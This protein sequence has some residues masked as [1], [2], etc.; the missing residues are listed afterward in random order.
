M[1][2][3]RVLLDTCV[4]IEAF[5][6]K[7]WKALCAHFDVETVDCCVTECASGSAYGAGRVSVPR[8]DLHAGLAKVHNVDA[9][10]L[11]ALALECP[12]LPALDDGELHIMA[13]LHA[14]PHAAV[15]TAISTAD[16]AAIRATHVMDLLERVRSLQDLARQAGVDKKQLSE[17]KAHF[18]DDWLSEARM[19]LEMKLM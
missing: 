13:W 10:M 1:P 11:A 6:T 17:L 16:R 19:K 9:L 18:G 7:C 12:D 2:K 4:I 5:R 8:K 3:P 15:V 14:N